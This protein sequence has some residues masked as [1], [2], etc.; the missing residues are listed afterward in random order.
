MDEVSD[1]VLGLASSS[2]GGKPFETLLGGS[3]ASVPSNTAE[4]ELPPV[5]RLLEVEVFQLRPE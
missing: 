3:V 5:V 2:S 4:S 1:A